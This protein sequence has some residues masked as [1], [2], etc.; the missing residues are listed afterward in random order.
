MS[1]TRAHVERLIEANIGAAISALTSRHVE[2][3]WTPALEGLTKEAARTCFVVR[4]LPRESEGYSSRN[5]T[6]S[7][8]LSVVASREDDETGAHLTEM[9]EDLLGLVGTWDMDSD[10]A[11]AALD[12]A[13]TF[14]CDG[15]MFAAGGD[16]GYDEQKASWYASVE[17]EIVGCLID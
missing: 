13:D 11:A 7:A 16:C 2:L 4:V 10:A 17:V 6:L 1:A 9:F 14:R 12:I 3:F 15:V 8:A 5:I